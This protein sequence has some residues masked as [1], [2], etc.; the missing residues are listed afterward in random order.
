MADIQGGYGQSLVLAGRGEEAKTHLNDA[1]NLARELKNDGLVAQT[2][3]FQGDAAYYRGDSKSARALYVQAL[4]AATRSKEPDRI[5]TANVNLAQVNLQEGQGQQAVASLRKLMQQAVDQGVPNISVECSIYLAE[6]M[7]QSHDNG[8][9]QQELQRALLRADKIGLKPLS[10]KAHY[11]MATSLRASGNQAEAHQHYR[12]TLQLLDG[13][14]HE[15]GADKILLR[16]DFRTMYD[17]CTR[18]SNAAKN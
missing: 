2:L 3:G 8:R 5:L 4:Q 13:M 12:D 1:L 17:E 16:S 15:P 6:A 9:A 14:R 11:L 7:I 18:S 10:A